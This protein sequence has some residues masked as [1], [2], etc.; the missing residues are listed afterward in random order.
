V[1]V[2]GRAL[3]VAGG[4]AAA[5]LGQLAD[6]ADREAGKMRDALD[7]DPCCAQSSDVLADRAG[8]DVRLPAA[9]DPFSGGG[10]AGGGVGGGA[11]GAAAAVLDVGGAGAVPVAGL[12]MGALPL[13]SCLETLG[14][15]TGLLEAAPVLRTRVP[16]MV[17]VGQGGG[18]VVGAVA[19]GRAGAADPH[20]RTGCRGGPN[21]G[22]AGG[23]WPGTPAR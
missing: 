5:V 20:R 16:P 15:A 18:G 8:V 22:G 11:V 2:L 6:V 3:R 13:H 19:A 21:L 4:V 17:R 1:A 7:A 9:V 10:A 23:V 14:S 12:R